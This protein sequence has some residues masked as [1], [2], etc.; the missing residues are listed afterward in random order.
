MHTFKTFSYICVVLA[1]MAGTSYSQEVV[2]YNKGELIRIAERLARANEC[3]TLLSI[4]YA[5]I[6]D[7]ETIIYNLEEVVEYQ[8][9]LEK[10]SALESKVNELTDTINNFNNQVAELN[11]TI[12]NLTAENK[13]LAEF[14]VSIDREKKNQL[15]SSFYMLSDEQKKDCID[16]IDTYSYDDI[17]AKLSVICVRNKVSFD[18]DKPNEPVTYNIDH[19]EETDASLP[20]WIQR[21]QEVAKEKNI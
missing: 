16:N 14:K 3:D 21:V 2:C 6:E 13:T 11:T 17:E 7:Y 18:L 20:A 12:E 4:A 10:Y 9:L 8:E 1:I 5:D 19:V 15:I